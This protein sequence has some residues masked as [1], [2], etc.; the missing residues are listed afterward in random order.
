LLSAFAADWLRYPY[1]N[2]AGPRIGRSVAANASTI[3]PP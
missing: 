1:A 2:I 3:A